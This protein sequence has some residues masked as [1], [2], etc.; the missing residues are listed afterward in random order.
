MKTE[1]NRSN[2]AGFGSLFIMSIMSGLLI[3]SVCFSLFFV[4]CSGICI[5]N[6]IGVLVTQ[7]LLVIPATMIVVVLYKNTIAYNNNWQPIP[8]IRTVV[9][10]GC[11]ILGACS[12][13]VLIP[14]LSFIH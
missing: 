2:S 4:E 14:L 1:V 12:V 6:L 7:W 11:N 8:F 9:P 5:G 13:F 3:G 10:L